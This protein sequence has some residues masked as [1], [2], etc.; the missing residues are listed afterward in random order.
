MASSGLLTS[1]A[2]L[3]A[4]RPIAAM[5]SD[6][7]RAASRQLAFGD[8]AGDLG[9]AD[10]PSRG[11]ADGRNGERDV[12]QLAVFA[13]PEGFEVFD[14]F[15]GGDFA[16]DLGLFGLKLGRDE[17]EDGLADDLVRLIAE[18]PGGS[19]IPTGDDTLEILADDGVVGGVDDGG[20]LQP[21]FD[22]RRSS[23]SWGGD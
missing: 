22:G 20:E 11:I 19:G 4:M 12:E 1:W 5:R 2:M 6:S 8:I 16:E 17:H 10:D 14:A 3:A 13:A 15:A 7:K 21:G 23:S 18:E 9:D